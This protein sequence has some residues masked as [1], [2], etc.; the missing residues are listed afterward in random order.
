MNL[1]EE[2]NRYE[3]IRQRYTVLEWGTLDEECLPIPFSDEI[4]AQIGKLSSPFV[5][6]LNHV[7]AC[8]DDLKWLAERPN[9]RGLRLIHAG[10]VSEECLDALLNSTDLEYLELFAALNV[11]DCYSNE[12]IKL[13]KS[14][15]N[16]QA[17][18]T[19]GFLLCEDELEILGQ[20]PNLKYLNMGLHESE[21]LAF[22]PNLMKRIAQNKSLVAFTP[23]AYLS[24]DNLTI[25]ATLSNLR[26]LDLSWTY[27]TG[28]S[29]S[30]LSLMPELRRLEL[31]ASKLVDKDMS[32]FANMPKLES[33]NLIIC[34]KITPNGF[35]PLK[36]LTELEQLDLSGCKG[37]NDEVLTFLQPLPRLQELNLDIWN[38][39][40]AHLLALARYP[41]LKKLSLT[42]R[43]KKN[44]LFA[45][46]PLTTI[47][48]WEE[49]HLSHCQGITDE[50]LASLLY[51]SNLHTLH[52]EEL[53]QITDE[54]FRLLA[55]LSCLESLKIER[56]A[57]I[58]DNSVLAL[59]E[60]TGLKSLS[61]ICC[62]RVTQSGI[63]RLQE[64]LPQCKIEFTLWQLRY[65]IF[66]FILFLFLFIGVP[67]FFVAVIVGLFLGAGYT[68]LNLFRRICQLFAFAC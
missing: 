24:A 13:L 44:P 16:L 48:T 59:A 46:L 66:N 5:V 34:S 31:D 20:L 7:D 25:L 39:T 51:N 42:I 54:G 14:L 55:S 52:L 63:D 43:G 10:N 17:F 41:Q 9:L 1:F 12:K 3:Q 68:L 19:V 37:L 27:V 6:L 8:D 58:T 29:L 49:L 11:G 22:I 26:T 23:W 65:E 30:T 50:G 33:L 32:V 40:D 35:E 38:L 61:I 67:L 21:E 53:S 60:I 4:K 36:N 47:Q 57:K 56:A 64:L 15:P 45:G 28:E 62:R 2:W 18:S